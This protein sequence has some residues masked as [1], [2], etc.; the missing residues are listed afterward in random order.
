MLPL[1][2]RFFLS[3]FHKRARKRL[4]NFGVGV[5]LFLYVIIISRTSF[6]V[7]LHSI[8]CLNVK[9]LLA[10][11]RRRIWGLSDSNGIRTHNQLV[12]KRELNHL[13]KRGNWPNWL[14]GW[15]FLYELSGCGFEFRCCQVTSCVMCVI[16]NIHIIN[17]GLS[18]SEKNCVICF[19]ESP[20]K[21]MKSSSYN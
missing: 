20:L 3:I 11:S 13:A 21:L 15:V 12:R 2:R 18:P 9:K 7:S 5:K 16:K 8:V 19:I 6:R 17:V 1:L 10:R 14:N 4:E